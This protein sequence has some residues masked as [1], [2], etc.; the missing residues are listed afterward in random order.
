[1]TAE[2]KSGII[3]GIITAIEGGWVVMN[4]QIS[5]WRFVRYL[6]VAPGMAGG[7]A[8]WIGAFL[9]TLIFVAFAL[10]LRSVRE[11]LFRPSLLKLLAIA[12]AIASGIL[13]EVM[14][15]RWTMNWLMGHSYGAFVQVLGSGLLFGAIHGIWGLMGKSFRAALGATIATGFLGGM[16]GIVFLLAGRSLAPC[17][18][19]HFAINLL[20]EPGLVL[21]ATRGEMGSRRGKSVN[22]TGL[23]KA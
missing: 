21:A 3:L 5:G 7:L 22:P 10:R 4:L 16:L 11:N 15:R 9:A 23:A 2:R 6:G 19:A 8:G 13:E 12:L 1:M 14:F 17:I 18:T 20:I